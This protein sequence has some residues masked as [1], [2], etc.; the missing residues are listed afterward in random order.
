MPDLKASDP[1]EDTSLQV[2]LAI[3]S[4]PERLNEGMAQL[5]DFTYQGCEAEGNEDGESLGAGESASVVNIQQDLDK[6]V[7]PIDNTEDS[8]EGDDSVLS[9]YS[10]LL[11]LDL[12]TKAPK[13]NDK[14]ADVADNL[15][16]HRV[17]TDQCKA[18]IKRHRTPENIKVHLPKC[19][20]SIWTQLSARTRANGAK[21]KTT[22]QILLAAIN[23]QLEVTNWLV[24]FKAS[25]ELLT[26]ALDGLTLSLTAN[27]AMNQRRRDAIKPQFKAEFAKALCSATNPVDEFLFGGDTSFCPLFE[28]IS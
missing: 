5:T 15:C 17:S 4:S 12:E 14:I 18:L 27:Y 25:K 13:V 24:N 11:E 20:N 3:L 6:I 19:E 2:N 21:L 1:V 16:L 7:K 23:C 10:S 26:S 22:Q 8:R 9:N 28:G